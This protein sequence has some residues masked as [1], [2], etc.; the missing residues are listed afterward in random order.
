MASNIMMNFLHGESHRKGK[1]TREEEAYARQLI[2]DFCG[3]TLSIPPKTSLRFYVC[4]ALHC[5]PMRLTKKFTGDMA[6]GK[7]RMRTSHAVL[8]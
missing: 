2:H 1:W 4:V 6:V 5:V 7:V 8:G 3:G